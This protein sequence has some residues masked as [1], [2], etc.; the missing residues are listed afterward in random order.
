LLKRKT[1]GALLFLGMVFLII[2]ITT[3]NA[4]FSWAAAAL[5][6]IFLISGGRWRK[7]LGRRRK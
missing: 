7:L 4:I 5:V 2:A 6:F 3:D 1:S